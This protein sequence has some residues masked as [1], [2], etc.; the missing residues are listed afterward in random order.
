[1]FRWPAFWGVLNRNGPHQAA[2]MAVRAT[3]PVA[4]VV[5]THTVA[6]GLVPEP[7]TEATAR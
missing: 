1:M 6:V 3:K 5:A 2:A 4:D 7:V